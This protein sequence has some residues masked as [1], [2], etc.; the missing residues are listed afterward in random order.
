MGQLL[1][2]SKPAT[3]TTHYSLLQQKG[4]ARDERHD[5]TALLTADG[6]PIPLSLSVRSQR[7]QKH[8]CDGDDDVVH[9]EGEEGK[10][11]RAGY[12]SERQIP[13][14]P[15]TWTSRISV[16]F[17][18]HF[19][20]WLR[21][22]I[23]TGIHVSGRVIARCHRPGRPDARAL[24]REATEATIV[25]GRGREEGH[26]SRVELL[27]DF[28]IIAVAAVVDVVSLST[29]FLLLSPSTHFFS[30]LP[31]LCTGCVSASSILAG[32]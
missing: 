22:K 7:T 3:F 19:L 31:A 14:Q 15:G 21:R 18:R 23:S 11:E 16:M 12:F 8:H 25:R 29:A 24:Q 10:S 32:Y 26:C 5:T 2:P 1:I 17:V 13:D 27:S 30:A 9:R 6:S 4:N 28:A 20:G